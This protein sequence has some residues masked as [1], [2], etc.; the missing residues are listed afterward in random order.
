MEQTLAE[1]ISSDFE[2]VGVVVVVLTSVM[3]N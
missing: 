2:V 3:C 1:L